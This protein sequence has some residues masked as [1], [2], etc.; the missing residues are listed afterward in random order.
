MKNKIQTEYNH[1]LK[2]VINMLKLFVNH[3]LFFISCKNSYSVVWNANSN[4][5]NIWCVR[6]E[7]ISII[8]NVYK[9]Y[10]S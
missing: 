8:K 1:F 10:Y 7:L 9:N 2:N 6:D 5:G 3:T 4:C